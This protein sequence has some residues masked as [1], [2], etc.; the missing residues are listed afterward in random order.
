MAHALLHLQDMLINVI[1]SIDANILWYE[2]KFLNNLCNFAESFLNY[3]HIIFSLILMQILRKISK[4]KS[5]P[6][7]RNILL[8]LIMKR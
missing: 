1:K 8:M 3:S 6:V 2:L 4:M 5:I 7:E